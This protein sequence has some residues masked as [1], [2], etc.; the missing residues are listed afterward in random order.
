MIESDSVASNDID[1]AHPM[2]SGYYSAKPFCTYIIHIF[3]YMDFV[4]IPPAYNESTPPENLAA[5]Y[6]LG[7]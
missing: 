2:L 3:S 6:R 1:I 7:R 4:T 5:T